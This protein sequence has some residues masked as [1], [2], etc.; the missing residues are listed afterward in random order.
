MKFLQ[1]IPRRDLRVTL[2]KKTLV[3]IIN[4]YSLQAQQ[5]FVLLTVI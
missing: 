1:E 3:F 5:I 2:L 4:D